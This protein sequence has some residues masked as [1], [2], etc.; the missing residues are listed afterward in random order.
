MSKSSRMGK[1]QLN[2]AAVLLALSAVTAAPSVSAADP[3]S[4]STKA[5][6]PCGGSRRAR[7]GNPCGANPC[8]GSRRQRRQAD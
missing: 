7:S 6:N 8:G 4:D 3:T 1:A 5:E 2:V